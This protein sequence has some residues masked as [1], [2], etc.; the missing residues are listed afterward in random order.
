MPETQLEALDEL[1]RLAVLLLKRISSSQSEL[2]VDLHHAG[3]K[4]A[5]IAE[6]VGTTANSAN[7]AIQRDKRAKKK[8][9]R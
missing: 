7:Q 4:T 3:I 2:I 9:G 8:E 5:R 1:S 6:L